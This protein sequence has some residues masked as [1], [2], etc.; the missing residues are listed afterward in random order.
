MQGYMQMQCEYDRV[1]KVPNLCSF[2]VEFEG[3]GSHDL[4]REVEIC[5]PWTL[6]LFIIYMFY[7]LGKEEDEA[8]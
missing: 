6:I 5:C 7:L 3:D 8:E 2:P 4:D 1:F